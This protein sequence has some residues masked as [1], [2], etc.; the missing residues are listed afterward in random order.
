MSVAINPETEFR[1][2]FYE[3]NYFNHDLRRGTLFNRAGTKMC[4]L[5]PELIGAMKRVLEEETGPA[6]SHILKRVGMIWGSRVAS[7]FTNELREYYNRPLHEMPMREMLTVLEGYFRYHGWGDL[8]LDMGWSESGLIMATMH[9]SAFAEI[10]GACEVPVD[11]VVA[12]LLS[13]FISE[14]SEREDIDCQETACVAMGNPDCRFI[15][16]TRARIAPLERWMELG[17][18][19][20]AIVGRLVGERRN[21]SEEK[22]R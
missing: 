20:D 4:F 6:W 1:V 12:G 5:P 21:S 8:R 17:M 10:F 18:D 3:E 7:R 11:S 14:V 2:P 9:N 22:T 13:R 15:V 16:G 19:H